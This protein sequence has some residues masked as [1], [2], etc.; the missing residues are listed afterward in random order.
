MT[1]DNTM[2]TKPIESIILCEG[3]YAIL[4]KDNGSLEAL[5]YGEPWRDLV[6]DN[7]VSALFDRVIELEALADTR[8]TPG[9]SADEALDHY[10]DP[11]PLHHLRHNDDVINLIVVPKPVALTQEFGA[12]LD[13]DPQADHEHAMAY[14]DAHLP[15]PYRCGQLHPSPIARDMAMDDEIERM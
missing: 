5:R 7:L 1:S 9:Y 8:V 15:M 12:E 14:H 2:T 10:P 3:K 4:R 13:P 6:G 11:P